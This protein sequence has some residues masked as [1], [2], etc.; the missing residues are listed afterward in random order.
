MKT[1]NKLSLGSFFYLVSSYAFVYADDKTQDV[2]SFVL[3][4]PDKGLFETGSKVARGL[5]SA[6]W[7]V[8]GSAAI[9]AITCFVSAGNLARQGEYGRAAGAVVGGMIAAL[10]AYFVSFVQK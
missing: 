8:K 6:E 3:K 1:I 7:L 5:F 2:S 9:F 4:D 10:G